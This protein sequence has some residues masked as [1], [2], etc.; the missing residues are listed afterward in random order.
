M[1]IEFDTQ[2]ELDSDEDAAS[3]SIAEPTAIEP[4]ATEPIK[5]ATE[6][7]V[8]K[9]TDKKFGDPIEVAKIIVELLCSRPVSPEDAKQAVEQTFNQYENQLR[10]FLLSVAKAKVDRILRYM[11]FVEKLEEELFRPER[12]K[13][14]NTAQLIKAY[15]SVQGNLKNDLDFI[16]TMA[17][18]GL[19]IHK[20]L[21]GVDAGNVEVKDKMSEVAGMFP[22]YTPEVR[23]RIRSILTDVLKI[24]EEEQKKKVIDITLAKPDV[25]AD[26]E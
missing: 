11:S 5:P 4:V 15:A 10:I 7:A 13:D 6:T 26:E 12:I 2:D 8:A 22:Q 14:A 19:E 23:G 16:K 20:I 25:D 21:G 9:V 18:M 17:D 3:E 24:I 1:T